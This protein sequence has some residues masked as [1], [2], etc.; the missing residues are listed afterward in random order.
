MV[1]GHTYSEKRI[2]GSLFF[3]NYLYGGNCSRKVVVINIRP[4]IVDSKQIRL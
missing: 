3:F 2:G 1:R 4:A